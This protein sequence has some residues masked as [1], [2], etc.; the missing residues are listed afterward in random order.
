MIYALTEHRPW[1]WAIARGLKPIENRS[2]PPWPRLIGQL[3]A[4]HSGC[5]WDKGGAFEVSER[6]YPVDMPGPDAWPSGRIV[7]VARLV[8]GIRPGEDERRRALA[9]Y[10]AQA[11]D[12]YI[13]QYGWVLA[14]HDNPKAPVRP[15]PKPVLAIGKQGLWRL[16][17]EQ[18]AAVVH[19]L[20]IRPTLAPVQVEHHQ[21][22]HP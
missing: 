20:S 2:W 11:M 19:Q 15:L 13:G 4:I 12:W 21:E 14:A 5:T 6:V 1:D 7:A 18:E 10:G 22:S 17:D 3:I 8:D 9:A 16:T